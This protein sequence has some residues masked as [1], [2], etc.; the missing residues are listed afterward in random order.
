M[1]VSRHPAPLARPAWTR[2]MVTAASVQQGELA[3][4]AKKV[5][6]GISLTVHT[7]YTV[8]KNICV[9]HNQHEML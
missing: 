2:L 6:P 5:Q 4:T 3:T 7:L 9:N 1:S 8:P